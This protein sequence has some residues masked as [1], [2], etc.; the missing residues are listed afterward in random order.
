[1]EQSPTIA[2]NA[3]KLSGNWAKQ[4]IQFSRNRPVVHIFIQLLPNTAK[5]TMASDVYNFEDHDF[6]LGS[7]QFT[8]QKKAAT[9]YPNGRSQ[10]LKEACNLL[11]RLTNSIT[12]ESKLILLNVSRK[13]EEVLFNLLKSVDK[14]FS[15]IV[16][17]DLFNL[18][19]QDELIDIL[20]SFGYIN[21]LFIRQHDA[22]EEGHFLMKTVAKMDAYCLFLYVEGGHV[23]DIGIGILQKWKAIPNKESKRVCITERRFLGRAILDTKSAEV[24]QYGKVKMEQSKDPDNPYL[25]LHFGY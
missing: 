11:G 15:D 22:D 10:S 13:D 18:R 6:K 14:S 9:V 3:T 20:N 2:S 19:R 8:G 12:S 25:C 24:R 17:I 7:L 16:L 23:M 4:S 1:M 5:V 21:N